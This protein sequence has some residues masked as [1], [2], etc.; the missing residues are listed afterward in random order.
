MKL[1]MVRHLWGS[2]LSPMQDVERFHKLGYAAIESP[3]MGS[4]GE[5]R[6]FATALA[7]R[8]M[9]WYAMA[10]TGGDGASAHFDSF[11]SQ[12]EQGHSL[13]VKQMTAHTGS[14][15]FSLSQSR[16]FYTRVVEFEK[17]CPVAVG[18]E[19]HRGRIFFN[20]WITRDLLDEFPQLRLCT[21]LSHWVCVTERLLP[22]CGEI[23]RQ[24]ARHT[25]HLHARV[26]FEHGPQVPDPS[27]PEYQYAVDAHMG[28]WRT[29]FTTQKSLGSSTMSVTPEFGPQRYMHSIP[30]T[31]V[32]VADLFKVCEYMTGR[33]K[34]AFVDWE[35]GESSTSAV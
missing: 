7:D 2:T 5:S 4:Q 32:P 13:G 29:I 16:D 34:Q 12:I 14:D 20:P 6:E 25:I 33:V 24:V 1:K 21:D 9:E 27:A 11:T 22:D 30:H 19:T 26:G 10:F 18:H 17:T 28:W 15:A 23:I 8:G 31:D 35:R 3:M